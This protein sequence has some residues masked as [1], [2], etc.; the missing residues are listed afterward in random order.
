MSSIFK[1]SITLFIILFIF[2]ALPCSAEWG[3]WNESEPEVQSTEE[4]ETSVPKIATL[5]VIRFYQVFIS[6]LLGK[7]KCNFTPS[8][9]RYGY[10][11][12]KDYGALQ[13]TIMAFERISRDHPWVRK[14]KYKIKNRL[15]YDPPSQNNWLL[16]K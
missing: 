11:A 3:P 9:S 15:R 7:G 2:H 5:S 8:C 13:G 6:P 10:K 14:E 12:I 1:I 16:N 4:L